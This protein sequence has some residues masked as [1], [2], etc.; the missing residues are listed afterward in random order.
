[1]NKII[2]YLSSLVPIFLLMLIKDFIVILVK[3]L[4]K[5]AHFLELFNLTF[6]IG[7]LL[8]FIISFRLFC[9][10]K[11]NKHMNSYR[12]KVYNVINRSSEYYLEYCSLFLV[13][14]FNFSLLDIE[15]IITF[16]LLVIFLGIVYI[17]NELFF[18]NPT[19]NIFQSMIY[20]VDT[21]NYGKRLVISKRKIKDGDIIEVYRSDFNFTIEKRS[22]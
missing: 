11:N 22:E 17:K 4:Y 5:E 15:N 16:V 20:E 6:I 2:M 14:L 12:I 3:V 18:I 13:S 9:L 19:I 1:M 8:C 10:I 21:E 7:F